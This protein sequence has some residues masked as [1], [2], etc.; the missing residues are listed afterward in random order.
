LVDQGR[1]ALDT[2]VIP[3][4]GLTGTPLSPDITLY[5]LLTHSSGIGD[6]ADE[7]SGESYE[8]LWQT[9]TSYLVRTTADF[10]PQFIHKP[11]NFP[12]GQGCRYCNVGYVL[13]GLAIEQASGLAYRDYVRQ[14]VFA[15]AGMVHSDFFAM[16]Q[17]EANVAEGADPVR[18]A[19][20]VVTAW[21]RNIF[22]Y[23]P[24]GSPD[25]GAHVTAGDL[26]RFLRQVR[27][28]RLLS[29]ALTEA[30]F[31]PQVSHSQDDGGQQG[32]GLGLWFRLDPAGRVVYAEKEGINAG[33]SA[34]LRHYP[35]Q[36]LSVVLL[37]NME[38]GVWAPIQEIHRR[39]AARAAGAET[40]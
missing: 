26:D 5:H 29:P 27:A 19:D 28:G 32:A 34:M 40:A 1:L 25:A 33:V 9:R 11:A 39:L 6:D 14:H 21:K 7:E 10:L 35:D 30:F 16:D 31:T 20:G 13:A 2:P 23:P 18:D 17:V 24:I 3:R 37:S 12:P 8:A 22:S 15:P 4:L 38:A 36:D